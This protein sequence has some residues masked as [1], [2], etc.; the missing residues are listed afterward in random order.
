MCW[1]G[2]GGGQS[3]WATL[4]ASGSPLSGSVLA[5]HDGLGNNGTQTVLHQC[6]PVAGSSEYSFGGQIRV[7][8][9]Q[10][11]GTNGRFFV[12]TYTTSNCSGSSLQKSDVGAS[13]IDNWTLVNKT[14]ITDSTANSMNIR[15][16]VTKLVAVTDDAISYFDNVF[17]K[18]SDAGGN[19]IIDEKLSGGWFTWTDTLGEIDWMTVQGG[20]SGEVATLTIYRSSGGKF[21]DP[22]AVTTV[23]IG[24]AEFRFSSCTDAEFAFM[25]D[26]ESEFTVTP[27]VRAGPAFKGCVD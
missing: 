8:S 22:A 9:D 12:F 13:D 23:P 3:E 15:F 5:T 16:G 19:R 26:D 2:T 4:D 18:K 7:P 1:K 20:F 21:N 25:F 14:L 6:I 24:I 10:P 11:D 17:V 27:M